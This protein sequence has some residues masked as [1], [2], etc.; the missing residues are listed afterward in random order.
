MKR[1]YTIMFVASVVVLVAAIAAL[2][3]F[4]LNLGVD[5][6]GGSVLEV[7]FTN[8]RPPLDDIQAK[9]DAST[10]EALHG[11]SLTPAGERGLIIRSADRTHAMHGGV[12]ITLER[13]YPDAG[14]KQLHFDF[15]GP[16]V[17][18]E[19]KRKSVTAILVLLAAVLAYIAWMFRTLSRSLSLWAMSAGTVLGLAHDIIIPMG[20]F[21]VLGRYAGVEISA[22]YVA[23]V[24]TILG[25]TVSD[26]VV[27]YDR[28]RENILRGM[29][30]PLAEVVHVSVMQTLVRSINNTLVVVLS[31]L[32]VFLFGGESIKF[33]ALA[34]MLGIALGAYSSI[35]VASPLLVWLSRRR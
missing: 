27:I 19:L 6:K 29:K 18:E 2:A 16:A 14:L 24:L 26:K 28:V 9:L 33:F 23:A 8:G 10:N 21:A 35:F 13:E 4:G 1:F 31:S 15:I 34:L 3:T 12:W 7:E 5:F 11:L 32:A 25:Y 30:A 22:I 17:G 20:V